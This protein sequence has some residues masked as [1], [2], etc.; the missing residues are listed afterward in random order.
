[1]Y[2][3]TL[4]TELRLGAIGITGSTKHWK[5]LKAIVFQVEEVELTSGALLTL[6]KAVLQTFDVK[7]RMTWRM[8]AQGQLS[9]SLP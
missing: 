7:P 5:I 4:E 2:L 6:A 3:G 1:L 8:Q 9:K